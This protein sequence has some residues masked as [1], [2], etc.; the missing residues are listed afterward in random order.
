MIVSVNCWSLPVAQLIAAVG[1]EPDAKFQP[2]APSE[3]V[4]LTEEAVHHEAI[5]D[6]KQHFAFY[7]H[8]QLF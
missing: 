6:T 5:D 2:A 3:V 1:V 7:I 8:F 4:E